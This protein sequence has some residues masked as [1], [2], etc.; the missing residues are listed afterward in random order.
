MPKTDVEGEED[1]TWGWEKELVSGTG[2][3]LFLCGMGTAAVREV[4]AA[5]GGGCDVMASS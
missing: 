1:R 2:G 4:G 3:E 5:G